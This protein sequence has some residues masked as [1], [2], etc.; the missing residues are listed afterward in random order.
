MSTFPQ[1]PQQVHKVHEVFEVRDTPDNRDEHDEH[2]VV[3]GKHKQQCIANIKPGQRCRRTVSSDI[4]CNRVC[5]QH[6]KEFMKLGWPGAYYVPDITMERVDPKL[7]SPMYVWE[8]NKWSSSGQRC[9]DPRIFESKAF[10]DDNIGDNGVYQETYD[11]AWKSQRDYTKK[12]NITKYLKSK[13]DDR[14][15]RYNIP[16]V[17]VIA[18]ATPHQSVTI[19]LTSVLLDKLINNFTVIAKTYD[20]TAKSGFYRFPLNLPVRHLYMMLD[21]YAGYQTVKNVN[22]NDHRTFQETLKILQCTD[23]NIESFV[24]NK[25]RLYQSKFEFIFSDNSTEEVSIQNPIIQNSNM[26][27]DKIEE[28]FNEQIVKS[29]INDD[30]NTKITMKLDASRDTIQTIEKLLQNKPIDTTGVLT[31]MIDTWMDLEINNDNLV[32]YLLHQVLRVRN[33]AVIKELQHH[34]N[35]IGIKTLLMLNVSNPDDKRRLQTILIHQY[36]SDLDE[37]NTID[38]KRYNLKG[39]VLGEGTFGRVIKTKDTHTNRHVAIKEIKNFTGSDFDKSL[40]LN[41]IN[42]L[43]G[44]C[45]HPYVTKLLDVRKS[46]DKF[47]NKTKIYLIF[48]YVPGDLEYF[49]YSQR[50]NRKSLMMTHIKR[51]TYQILTGVNWLHYNRIVHRDIKPAN[52]LYDREKDLTYITD[53]GASKEIG[54]AQRPTKYTYVT[55]GYRAPELFFN[56]P[57]LSKS[58]HNY[59]VDSWSV[60]V[61]LL[62]M[63]TVPYVDSPFYPSSDRI[64]KY[65]QNHDVPKTKTGS[66]D[67]DKIHKVISISLI[68]DMLLQGDPK[69][70]IAKYLQR[71]M[72]KD[73][74]TKGGID[75][76]NDLNDLVDLLAGLLS[77]DPDKRWSVGKALKSRWFDGVDKRIPPNETSDCFASVCDAKPIPTDPRLLLTE[78]VLPKNTTE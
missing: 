77:I 73:K 59:K 78:I 68:K 44:L 4:G 71:N 61:I 40:L 21:Y 42:I 10:N 58:A 25:I 60:G 72:G 64:R 67:W 53:L 49:L 52:I 2:H 47:T 32:S 33:P 31:E 9:S 37:I 19:P 15:A 48:D 51:L 16:N 35:C 20:N 45:G 43:I 13:V 26:I 29:E 66:T 17:Y 11:T 28:S 5:W 8:G 75:D 38:T 24:E 69:K 63:L 56:E 1:N 22:L 18:D 6:A 57:E 41:E 76:L 65:M 30:V 70:S 34:P 62:E 7:S 46:S 23:P 12:Q 54:E 14:Y 3:R 55:L 27:L 74:I 50:K 39:V 36:L